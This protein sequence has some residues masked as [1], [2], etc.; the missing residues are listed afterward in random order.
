MK[1]LVTTAARLENGMLISFRHYSCNNFNLC[2]N[3][4]E[5]LKTIREYCP[6]TKI[7]SKRPYLKLPQDK[8][9]EKINSYIDKNTGQYIYGNNYLAPCDTE[10]NFYDYQKKVAFSV[11]G[12]SNNI[13]FSAHN[14]SNNPC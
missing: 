2:L 6:S 11:N 1:G 7:K 10:I 9:I 8:A 13:R 12:F 4:K 5:F 14:F 3:D